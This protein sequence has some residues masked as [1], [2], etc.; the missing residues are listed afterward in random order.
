MSDV[1]NEER[2]D[3]ALTNDLP[4]WR[5]EGGELVRVVELAGF[6]QAIEVV[7][8]VALV[9]EEANHHPDIDI[10]WR[11]VTFHLTTHSQNG[12]TGAD[13]EMAKKIDTIIGDRAAI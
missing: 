13:L 5:N 1:L 6:P 7:N 12:I 4:S 10:R 3:Q 8:D 11:T 2:I 9:A